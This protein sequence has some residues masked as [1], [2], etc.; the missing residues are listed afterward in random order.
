MNKRICMIVTLLFLTL[1]N[2]AFAG[3]SDFC[4]IENHW[5]KD[6]IV[7]LSIDGVV[8]GYSDSTFRPNEKVT[9]AEF[10]KMMVVSN[11]Y[12]LKRVGKSMWPYFYL[13]TAR[14][15][16]LIDDVNLDFNISITR[17]QVVDIISKSID[18]SAVSK[19]KNRFTDIDKEHKYNILKLV[20]LNI[21]NGYSDKTFKGSNSITRAEAVTIIKRLQEAKNKI[22]VSKK[23]EPEKRKD[24]SNYG[25]ALNKFEFYYKTIGKD[26]LI[27]DD[28]RY[29]N[30]NGYKIDNKFINVSKV[31]KVINS[32]IR[33]N[34][35]TQVL[36]SPSEYT[37]N[38]LKI[39]HGDTKKQLENNGAD[40]TFT[41]YENKFYDLANRTKNKNFS[42]ECYLKIEVIKLW[43]DYSDYINKNYIDEAKK[44]IL[45]EALEAEFGTQHGKSIFEYMRD[46]DIEFVTNANRDVEEFEVKEF[47]SYVINYYKREF[48]VP[49]FYFYTTR[50]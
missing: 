48:G 30:S 46:K 45:I 21:I 40:F 33:E 19:S 44:E 2:S 8:N 34:T 26:L 11:G 28:G 6:N 29:S 25:D 39:S 38:Q 10:L 3:T 9:V 15:N 18:L 35:Y 22:G 14:E 17:Y 47:G 27:Y 49:T 36:Y 42:D 16:N 32:L 23:Y 5:A 4:D 20:N 24:L 7:K 37:I 43:R 13:E 50:K 12:S 31:I 41:Y 1:T